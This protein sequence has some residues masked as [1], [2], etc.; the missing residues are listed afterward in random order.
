MFTFKGKKLKRLFS[1][2]SFLNFGGQKGFNFF[3]K[4]NNE[5]EST[6]NYSMKKKF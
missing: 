4:I 6:L 2:I 3:F 1:G 5:K